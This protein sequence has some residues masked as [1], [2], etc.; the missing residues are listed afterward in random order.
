MTFLMSGLLI[1]I[2]KV[3]VATITWILSNT[4]ALWAAFL[5][6][7]SCWGSRW[8]WGRRTAGQSSW[9]RGPSRLLLPCVWPPS[10]GSPQEAWKHSNLLKVVTP[11]IADTHTTGYW[12]RSSSRTRPDT[13]GS[14]FSNI[15]S[16]FQWLPMTQLATTSKVWGLTVYTIGH[17]LCSQ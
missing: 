10:R 2:L 15:E 4:K 17:I 16:A 3:M 9:R 11:A 8:W 12:W 1:P 7:S 5:V 14:R 6:M 13:T